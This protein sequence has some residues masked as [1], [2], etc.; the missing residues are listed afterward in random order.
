MGFKG[1]LGNKGAHNISFYL[2]DMR[3]L[4][5]NC[6]LQAHEKGEAQRNEQWAEIN[7]K[8]VHRKDFKLLDDEKND[9]QG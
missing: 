2:G 3:M 4:F 8:F 1:H 6:H 5:I 7:S 9:E